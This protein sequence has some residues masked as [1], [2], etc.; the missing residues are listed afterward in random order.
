MSLLSEFGVSSPERG[1]PQ[2]SD[3]DQAV[4]MAAESGEMAEMG[5]GTVAASEEE[6]QMLKDVLDSIEMTLHGKGSAKIESIIEKAETAYEGVAA[7]AHVLVLGSY[8]QAGKQG[9]E[10]SDDV[11]FAENGVIQT[12]TELVWEVANAMGKVPAEDDGQF[13]AALFD[14]FRRIGETVVESDNP[15]LAQSAQEF[16]LELET[17]QSI[18][19]LVPQ[20]QTYQPWQPGTGAD[21]PDGRISP[22]PQRLS[23]YEMQRGDMETS[24]NVQ[25]DEYMHT[26]RANNNWRNK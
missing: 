6:H 26:P 14:T 25:G 21:A 12:T 3:I 5:F 20:D 16:M 8:A 9:L 15:E 11:Y 10:V 17:G 7:A 24:P 19:S 18:D 2:S 13:E 4:G 23:P 1:K 22:R